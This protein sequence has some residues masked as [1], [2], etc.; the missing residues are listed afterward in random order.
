MSAGIREQMDR[1]RLKTTKDAIFA[2]HAQA[3]L[4][5]EYSDDPNNPNVSAYLRSGMVETILKIEANA[6]ASG[7]RARGYRPMQDGIDYDSSDQ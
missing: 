6:H 2:L 1:A 4:V 5:Q 3:D 7:R